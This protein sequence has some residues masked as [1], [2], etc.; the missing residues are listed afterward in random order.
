VIFGNVMFR[1]R[2]VDDA[3]RVWR[4][5]TGL[6]ADTWS[7]GS[8]DPGLMVM[9]AISAAIVFLAPNTQQIMRRFDPALNWKEWRSV[10]PPAI[11]WVWKP[12]LPGL[13]FAATALMFGV[14]FIE[15]GRAV[16]LYF[17]F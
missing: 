3:V 1:A 15:R 6:R 16:F 12:S 2:S 17:N 4:G 10:A 5:M 9:L 13:V 14:L 7:L 8:L 11:D